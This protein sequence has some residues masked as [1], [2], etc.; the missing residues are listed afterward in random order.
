LRIVDLGT[1]GGDLPRAIVDWA[2]KKGVSVE[3]T[4]VD[5]NPFMVEFSRQKATDYPEISFEVVD[6]FAPGF[7]AR[8][9]DVAICSLFCHHFPG[10][11][12]VDLFR[13]MRQQSRLA[14]VINDLHRHRLAWWGIRFLTW[15]FRG[16]YLVRHDGPLSVLRAF[17]RSELEAL[18]QEAGLPKYSLRWKWAFRWQLIVGKDQETASTKR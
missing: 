8:E 18:L 13:Q 6:I 9:W 3:V 7:R 14:L 2:R 15:L 5:A 10:P 12:L 16:S 11:A 4:G 1:G 17:K